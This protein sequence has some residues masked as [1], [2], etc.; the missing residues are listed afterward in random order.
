MIFICFDRRIAEWAGLWI[1]GKRAKLSREST[2][3]VVAPPQLWPQT[4]SGMKG[5][6]KNC[7]FIWRTFIII[8]CLA[9]TELPLGVRKWPPVSQLIVHLHW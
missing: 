4:I 2:T 6:V 7:V 5:C 1:A 9:S 8:P 3:L